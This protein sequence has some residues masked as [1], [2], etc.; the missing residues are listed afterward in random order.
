MSFLEHLEDFRKRLIYSCIALGVGMAVSFGFMDRLVSFVLAPTLRA[1]PRGTELIARYHADDVDVI[2]SHMYLWSTE[3]FGGGRREV[4]L[5]PRHSAGL[6]ILWEIGRARTG[7]ELFYTGPQ[8][9]EDN[10][11]RLRGAP[12]L[13]WGA[14]L[15][16][17]RR[18]S[19]TVKP[20]CPFVAKYIARNP[21]YKDLIDPAFDPTRAPARDS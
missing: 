15:D 3:P 10:P 2:L 18:S 13:L 5:N 7:I 6:D 1:L 12:Y 19:L 8:A 16:Y 21:E 20:Y 17:A 4:P 11:Y 14:L 9:L